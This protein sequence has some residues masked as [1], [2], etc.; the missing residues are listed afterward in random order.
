MALLPD[1]WRTKS[2]SAIRFAL[3]CGTVFLSGRASRTSRM[4]QMKSRALGIATGALSME[5]SCATAARGAPEEF[6]A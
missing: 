5:R 1:G 3:K 4:H 6:L 2:K